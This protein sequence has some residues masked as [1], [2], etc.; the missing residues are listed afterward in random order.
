MRAITPLM[1]IAGIPVGQRSAKT[2]DPFECWG[3]TKTRAGNCEGAQMQK[4]ALVPKLKAAGVLQF[5]Q[6]IRC[7]GLASALGG[8][9]SSRR[10]MRNFHMV[11]PDS[12][13][14]PSTEMR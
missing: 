8:A 14:P 11:G 10:N 1:E 12:T 6:R 13:P 7:S 4:L 2:A 9:V 5:C 3:N